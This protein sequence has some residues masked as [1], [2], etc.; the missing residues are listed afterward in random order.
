MWLVTTA[1]TLGLTLCAALA[2]GA[3]ELT[4]A[5]P[6]EVGLS[7]AR[8]ARITETLK[9]DVERGRIPG[10]V[11][12]IARR[13]RIAYAEAVGFRD[14]LASAPMTL[15]A[16][17][18]IASMTKPMVSVAA[19]MLYEDGK[20]F[21]SDP[22]SKYI[23][24]IGKMQVGAERID[25]MSGKSVVALTPPDREMTVQD[26]LRHT[27][28]LT[29]G[30]RGTTA[31]HKAYPLSSSAAAREV[32]SKEFIERVAKA[33]LLFSPGTHW[34]YSFS[35]DVLGRV[36]EVTSGQSLGQFLSERLFQPLKMA[37]T[38]F[39]V[40]AAKQARI[41]QPLATDPE[42]GKPVTVPDV[43]VPAKFE[44]GGGCAV[45]TAGDYLRFAQ[46]MLNRG[47][48]DGTR[49]LG[50]KTVE[51]MTSDHLG[52]VTGAGDYLPGS[53]YGFGL[54]FAVRRETGLAAL[55]GSAGDYN[56]GG[57]YGTAFWIDPREQLVVVA[58][59]QAPGAIR[60]HYRQL[61]KSFVLQAITD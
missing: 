46:M 14:K 23:P 21:V 2:A 25:P 41:A 20:L 38:G 18:R 33:P 1:F 30:N 8:L 45:A 13:G 11:V 37:D 60:V 39:W 53:G 61:L 10:A 32:T 52:T 31:I 40:P 5:K 43:T 36:V 42:T 22:V 55:T 56:W 35:T 3:A 26:L 28:G 24:E 49:I 12:V 29:Y 51:Y 19:M 44:C 6:E 48:L 4:A 15:D 54:G 27:S 58:M 47:S 34:E 16:I 7:S 59:T 9:A 17:F 50:R 57:A